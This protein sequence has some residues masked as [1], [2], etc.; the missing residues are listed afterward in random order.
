M[1]YVKIIEAPSDFSLK[2]RSK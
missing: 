1:N 2:W